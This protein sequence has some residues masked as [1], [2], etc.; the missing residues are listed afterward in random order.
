[1]GWGAVMDGQW[2]MDWVTGDRT[3]G[4]WYGLLSI[5]KMYQLHG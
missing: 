4:A 2:A 5:R 3:I 1:M